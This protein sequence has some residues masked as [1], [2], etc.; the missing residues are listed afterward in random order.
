MPSS[1]SKLLQK[2]YTTLRVILSYKPLIYNEFN[3]PCICMVNLWNLLNSIKGWFVVKLNYLLILSLIIM[4]YTPNN[5]YAKEIEK[6]SPLCN[7]PFIYTMVGFSTPEFDV[8]I[9][10]ASDGDKGYQYVGQDRKTKA[11]IVLPVTWNNNG[12]LENPWILK[13]KNGEYTYQVAE[14][15]PISG[16]KY[17]S[18]SVFKNGA[19]IYQQIVNTVLVGEYSDI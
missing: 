4:A 8:A 14:F 15:N 11:K 9:C 5:V 3:Y 12:N 10:K 19:R 1:V 16:N 18:L 17:A 2:N 13:A 6:N 7:D